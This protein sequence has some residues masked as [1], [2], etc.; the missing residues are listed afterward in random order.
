MPQ[1]SVIVPVYNVEPYLR[2]CVDS[3]LAQT[4]TDFELILVDDGSTDRSGAI[5]DA[6]AQRDLRV[7]VIRQENGGQSSAR[8][9]GLDAARGTYICFI[10]SD[11][12]VSKDLLEKAIHPLLNG[13][14]LS[15]FQHCEIFPK[16]LEN[17]SEYIPGD[18]AIHDQQERLE[19]IVSQLLQGKIGWGM[20]RMFRREI[21]EKNHIRF[22]DNRKIFAEDLCFSLYYCI[23][24]SKISVI[25]DVL[26]HYYVRDDSTMGQQKTVLNAGRMQEL[27]KELFTF[28]SA[29]SEGKILLEHFPIIYFF[30]VENEINRN[31]KELGLSMFDMRKRLVESIR[32]YSFLQ[33]QMRG[34]RNERELL[35][36]VY[37]DAR[38]VGY[39]INRAEYY[40]GGN[41]AL[42][43]LKRF[44]T[45]AAAFADKALKK[46]STGRNR[47]YKPGASHENDIPSEQNEQ[48][49]SIHSKGN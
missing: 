34:L 39:T 38:Q 49:A 26:Y 9:A 19:F 24:V 41:E 21:I 40:A 47:L 1:I 16:G 8:N 2:R 7:R 3:I 12:S 43:I 17:E 25:P 6:F 4:F 5:C 44:S 15:V 18:I 37:K 46:R 35:F 42:F 30:V 23:F 31:R 22:I 45:A 28:Y 14:E 11:D 27:C 10:D 13:A 48:E 29:H 33:K 36:R 32:D 20:G